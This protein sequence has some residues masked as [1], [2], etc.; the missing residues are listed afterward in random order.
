MRDVDNG[1]DPVPYGR[2]GG[3]ALTAV[4]SSAVTASSICT[5]KQPMNPAKG[6]LS[7]SKGEDET[8]QIN[9]GANEAKYTARKSPEK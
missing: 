9:Q 4:I 5:L 1:N 7:D 2:L 8:V 6:N 3:L